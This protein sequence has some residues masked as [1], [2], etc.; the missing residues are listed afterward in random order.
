MT[1]HIRHIRE[2]ADGLLKQESADR[3]NVQIRADAGMVLPVF[4][5]RSFPQGNFV[6]KIVGVTA[7]LL[8]INYRKPTLKGLVIH[9]GDQGGKAGGKFDIVLE[10]ANEPALDIFLIFVGRICEDIENAEGR[11]NAVHRVLGQVDRWLSF[12]SGSSEGVLS[13]TKQTGLYGELLQLE[14]FCETGLDAGCVFGAWTGSKAT[15]QDF[16]FGPVAIE[17]KSTVAKETSEFAV[18]NIRQLDPTG[19]EYLYLFRVAFDV[20]QGD[21]RTLPDLVELLRQ[22]VKADAAAHQLQFEENLLR[23]GYRDKHTDAYSRR[24]YTPR[25]C[26]QYAVKG[27][28]PRLEETDIPSG[29]LGVTYEVSLIGCEKFK[30]D[31]DEV[32]KRIGAQ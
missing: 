24:S 15:N 21:D 32:V 2:L 8:P 9:W 28:F 22:R 26:D 17:V 1:D 23:S 12:F 29:V 25:F 31:Y 18:S 14:R 27:G 3:E 11:K 7:D 20:R 4:L 16:E 5:G 10:L 19:V 13:E 30:T 6:A